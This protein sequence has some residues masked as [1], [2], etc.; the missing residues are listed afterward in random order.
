M[1]TIRGQDDREQS[2]S[3]PCHLSVVMR[4]P[5][6][7]LAGRSKHQEFLTDTS[8]LGKAEERRVQSGGKLLAC[9]SLSPRHSLGVLKEEV[10]TEQA[11]ET[12]VV[13]KN[14]SRIL[15]P[16]RQMNWQACTFEVVFAVKC[17]WNSPNLAT[18]GLH[19]HILLIGSSALCSPLGTLF[20]SWVIHLRR[21]TKS[22]RKTELN[23]LRRPCH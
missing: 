12:G 2:L 22:R 3:W 6:H 10:E 14:E 16:E 11:V 13:A 8:W 18:T 15:E 1:K 19:D 20:L 7:W 9:A 5:G 23:R 4:V 17:R 21:K